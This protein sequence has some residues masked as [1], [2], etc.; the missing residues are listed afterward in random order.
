M[1]C[2][3]AD[4]V[5]SNS[6]EDVVEDGASVRRRL[7]VALRGLNYTDGA[8]EFIRLHCDGQP[9]P[10]MMNFVESALNEGFPLDHVIAA[11][12]GRS[13]DLL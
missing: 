4:S 5:W 6:L 3:H 13:L 7:E 8:D 12:R 2:S 1:E 10:P 11:L 9:L